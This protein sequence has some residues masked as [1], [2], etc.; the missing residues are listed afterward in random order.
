M[1][2]HAPGLPATPLTRRR[3]IAAF[4]GPGS[5]N[6]EPCRVCGHRTVATV[7][8]KRGSLWTVEFS[9]RSCG[10]DLTLIGTP[11]EVGDDMLIPLY[12]A[13]AIWDKARP[14]QAVAA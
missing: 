5:L 13:I 14:A 11:G 1:S 10:H 7:I 9:C 4:F 2:Q 6:L 3:P 12:R 8:N